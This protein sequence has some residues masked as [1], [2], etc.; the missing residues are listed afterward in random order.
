MDSPA[1]CDWVFEHAR[2]TPERA[3]IDSPSARVSYGALARRVLV[4][5]DR[6]R[7]FGISAGDQVLVAL[8]NSPAAVVASLAVQ[9]LGAVSVEVSREW[10]DAELAIVF[11]QTRLSC[12]VLAGKDASKFTPLMRAGGVGSA[13]VVHSGEMPRRTSDLLEGIS[14]S[15]IS[16]DGRLVGSAKTGETPAKL[17]ERDGSAVTLLLYT[18]GSTGRPRAVMQTMAN[19]AANTRSIVSYLE[20]TARD[21]A[22]LVLPLSYCYGRSVLQTHLFVGGSIFLDS[23]FAYPGVVLEAIGA[24]KC[25]GFSG[26]PLTFELLRR[27]TH[28][29]PSRMPTLRYLTQAGGAM[30][31]ET[32]DWVRQAFSSA[33]LFIMYGQ[34]EATARLSYVPPALAAAKRGSIGIPIPGVEM[35]V[36]DDAGAEV[37][38][39]THGQI[40]ARGPNITPGYYRSEE[41]TAR[42]LRDGWLWTGDIGYRDPD[43]FFYLL[44]RAKDILKVGGHRVNPV[45]IETVLSRH[46]QVA[47]AAVAGIPDS[48]MGEVPAALVVAESGEGTAETEL[49]RF[50]S[51]HLPPYMVPRIVRIVAELPRNDAGKLLRERVAHILRDGRLP[52]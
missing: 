38:P 17:P 36:V 42:I 16:D 27:M 11:E 9:H 50:C 25:T 22:M 41:D 46:P 37:P 15:Q 48:L 6:L 24:E 45:Q 49:R 7:E 51:Q 10:S 4:L 52:G 32:A 13:L 26:V 44:G 21:R 3:A 33:E 35:R 39:G 8:P 28:P 29:D 34:T 1:I 31:P 20:L 40:V 19:I 14:L 23:R 47:A 2:R 43:G 30:N 12:A 18:S 5:A